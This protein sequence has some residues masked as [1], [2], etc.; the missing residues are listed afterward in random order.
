[1]GKISHKRRIRV[2]LPVKLEVK[3][4]LKACPECSSELTL[5]F[6]LGKYI[7]MYCAACDMFFRHFPPELLASWTGAEDREGAEE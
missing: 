2:A 1:M 6:A 4:P 7:V 5:D 3:L